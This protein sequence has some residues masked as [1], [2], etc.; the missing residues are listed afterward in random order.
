MSIFAKPIVIDVYDPR[1][2]VNIPAGFFR[3]VTGERES[4]GFRDN[5]LGLFWS[6]GK[7]LQIGGK[8][9]TVN[10]H[11]E[12]PAVRRHPRAALPPGA[13]RVAGRDSIVVPVFGP[14]DDRE[15]TTWEGGINPSPV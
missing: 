14:E 6:V 1:D 15:T 5:A 8:T 3:V 2:W 7:V 10:E 9:F 13:I 11:D 12:L 4:L